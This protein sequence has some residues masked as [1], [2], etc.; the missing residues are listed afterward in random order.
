MFYLY[1]VRGTVV[2]PSSMFVDALHAQGGFLKA[3]LLLRFLGELLNCGLVQPQEYGDMLT[4][5]CSGYVTTEFR[6]VQQPCR[7]M[8]AHMVLSG[9]LRVGPTLSKVIPKSFFCYCCYYYYYCYL[10]LMLLLLVF[11]T[12]PSLKTRRHWCASLAQHAPLSKNAID[13]S[14]QL[15]AV[16]T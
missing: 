13:T 4:I 12:H 2:K 6:H 7:D 1:Q 8:M 3:K 5:L 11:A 15:C 14:Y 10:L 16:H 9:V